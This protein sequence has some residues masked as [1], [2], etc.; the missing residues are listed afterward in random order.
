MKFIDEL[1][2]IK[3]I[4]TATF[5]LHNKQLLNKL[6]IKPVTVCYQLNNDK[7]KKKNTLNVQLIGFRVLYRVWPCRSEERPT[8]ARAKRTSSPGGSDPCRSVTEPAGDS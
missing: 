1:H 2:N 7:L 4:Y 8:A 5:K 3:S 6:I